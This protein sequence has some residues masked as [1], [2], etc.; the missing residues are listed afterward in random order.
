MENECH[1]ERGAKIKIRKWL[2][3]PDFEKYEQY[4]DEWH[5]FIS[6]ITDNV[7][8]IPPEKLKAWDALILQLFYFTDYDVTANFYVQFRARLEEAKKACK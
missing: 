3:T 7:K 6:G 1:K 2:D 4:I 8:N 5:S